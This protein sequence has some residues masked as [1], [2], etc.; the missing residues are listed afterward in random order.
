MNF[1][2]AWFHGRMESGPRA[3]GNR[4]I[5]MSP[6]DSKNKDIVNSKIKYRESFRP[7]CPSILAEYAD[8]YFENYRNEYFMTTSFKTSAKANQIPAVVHKDLT[9]RPQFV[10]KEA[11]NRYHKLI[12]EFYKLS[13]IPALLN[14]SFNVKGEPMICNPREAIKCFYDTGLDVLVIESFVLRKRHVPKL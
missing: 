4:S 14:T 2:L 3:L 12:T 5:L 9:A 8:A 10:T 1:T 13:G 7:F 11:N 6:R